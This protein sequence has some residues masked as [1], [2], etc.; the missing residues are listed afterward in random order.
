MM[1]ICTYS[2]S[3]L[4]KLIQHLVYLTHL[5]DEEKVRH[6]IVKADVGQKKMIGLQLHASFYAD[7]I[8]VEGLSSLG[9]VAEDV[10][11]M[12]MLGQT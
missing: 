6:R 5:M 8:V 4:W 12:A 7:V 2:K 1:Q 9:E 3:F 10:H 11:Y